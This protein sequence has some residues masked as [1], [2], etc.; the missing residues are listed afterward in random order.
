MDRAAGMGVQFADGAEGTLRALAVHGC[1]KAGVAARGG[2][3]LLVEGCQFSDGGG[4]V[5]GGKA[6]LP[7][8]VHHPFRPPGHSARTN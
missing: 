8:L 3:A 2:G 5:A 6:S 1:A 7:L 4:T